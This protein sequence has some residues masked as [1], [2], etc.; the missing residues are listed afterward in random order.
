MESISLYFVFDSDLY[1]Y[2]NR[3]DIAQSVDGSD[4]LILQDQRRCSLLSRVHQSVQSLLLIRK[5]LLQIGPILE[6]QDRET[7]FSRGKTKATLGI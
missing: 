3:F 7:R 5:T 2:G 4:A 6:E 1:G